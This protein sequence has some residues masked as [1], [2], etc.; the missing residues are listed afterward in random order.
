V[1]TTKIK[2]LEFE[3][4][5]RRA[6]GASARSGRIEKVEQTK[7]P[8]LEARGERAGGSKHG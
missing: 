6:Q 8:V 7:K 5:E 4:K 3:G 2:R 1:D